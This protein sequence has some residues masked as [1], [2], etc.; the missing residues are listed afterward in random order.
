MLLGK[1]IVTTKGI[2][3][4]DKVEKDN[5]GYTIEESIDDLISLITNISRQEMDIKGENAKT[6]WNNKYSTYT[7][8]FLENK[9]LPLIKQ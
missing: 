4:G 6:L 9:Y 8:D 5:I 2:I 1:P 7:H 3:I